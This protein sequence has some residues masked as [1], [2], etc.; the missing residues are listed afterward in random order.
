MSEIVNGL[1]Q[2]KKYPEFEMDV[3]N[4]AG[5]IAFFTADLP[6][7]KT[8]QTNDPVP[9]VRFLFKSAKIPNL[10]KW[11][12][13]F[14]IN[15]ASR[16]ALSKFF[17]GFT[18]LEAMLTNNDTIFNRMSCKILLEQ[19]GEFSEILRAKPGDCDVSQLFYDESYVPNKQVK[20]WGK[21]V[22]LTQA[23][24]KLESGIKIYNPQDMVDNLPEV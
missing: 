21:F 23:Y 5:I 18:N 24:L 16:S 12:K 8:A 17:Q 10:R 2:I 9:S 13:W 22:Y 11:S 7:G 15:Y 20:A 19:K 3:Y 6:P 4:D 1:K 14:S